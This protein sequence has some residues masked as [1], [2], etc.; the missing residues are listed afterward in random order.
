[1]PLAVASSNQR[2]CVLT[3]MKAMKKKVGL[4]INFNV[5][6]LKD[7]IKRLVL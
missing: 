3:Y 2:I 7:G 1:M 5:E 6:R 4:L